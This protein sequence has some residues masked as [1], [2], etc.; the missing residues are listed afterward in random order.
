MSSSVVI[1]EIGK[2]AL[3][4]PTKPSQVSRDSTAAQI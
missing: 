4:K 3:T 1:T 2:P